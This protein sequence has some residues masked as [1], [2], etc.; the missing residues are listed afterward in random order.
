MAPYTPTKPWWLE[1]FGATTRHVFHASTLCS[2]HTLAQRWIEGQTVPLIPFS[3][4][5]LRPDTWVW[6]RVNQQ[7]EGRGQ[8]EKPFFCP[9]GGLYASLICLWPHLPVVPLLALVTALAIA[10]SVS[11]QCQLKWVN[12]IVLAENKL[13]GILID[14]HW[15]TPLHTCIISFGLNINTTYTHT[16]QHR[17]ISSWM[18]ATGSSLDL[19]ALLW[20]I[21]DQLQKRYCAIIQN[22]GAL[23]PNISTAIN[24]RL[25]EYG[26]DVLCT[27]ASG[28]VQGL[29]HGISE[30]GRLIIGCENGPK[31]YDGLTLCILKRTGYNDTVKPL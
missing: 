2:S 30:T 5:K 13:G 1:P 20:R 31:E 29:C 24:R 7:T 17:T 27:T 8:G 28:S 25:R 11:E 22:G 26:Q 10:E 16:P 12:D 6:L 15:N 3:V 18:N 19:S 14:R 4:Q 23:G 21:Q 9:P